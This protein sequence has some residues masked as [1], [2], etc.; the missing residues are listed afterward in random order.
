MESAKKS[1]IEVLVS[2]I[3]YRDHK[4]SSSDI[5]QNIKKLC[6]QKKEQLRAIQLVDTDPLA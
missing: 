6:L 1:K 2:V 4:N 5:V 3:G